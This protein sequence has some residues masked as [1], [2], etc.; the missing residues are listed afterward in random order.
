MEQERYYIYKNDR[1]SSRKKILHKNLT[2]NEAEALL[3][4]STYYYTYSI[5][6]MLNKIKNNGNL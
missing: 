2:F 4:R 6:Q 5:V 3:P 1:F